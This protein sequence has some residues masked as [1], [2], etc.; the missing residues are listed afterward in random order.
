MEKVLEILKNK[1]FKLGVSAIS[2][3]YAIFCGYISWLVLAFYLKPTNNIS[4]FALYLFINFLFGAEMFYTRKSPVTRI[5][6]VI[7]PFEVFFM[8]I[9]G[10]GQWFVLIPP[11]VVCM[12]AFFASD[13][14]E[15]LKTVLGTI[16]L[17]LFVVGSLAYMTFLSFNISLNYVLTDEEMDMSLRQEDSYL[18]STDGTYRLVEYVEKTQ[19]RTT[20]KYYVELA[21]EDVHLPFIDC[22]RVL[23]CKKVL[24]S[25]YK[26]SAN[27]RWIS[28]TELYI[29][30]KKRDMEE[31]FADTESEDIVLTSA[32]LSE[33]PD[34]LTTPSD[35]TTAAE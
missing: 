34:A 21:S 35:E 12:F 32:V 26:E 18:V 7:V 31:L 28:D 33:A 23:G 13:N 22:Y 14:G 11:L 30:G 9:A 19:D 25:V 27:P 2:I 16:F 5:V 15:T 17:L 6:S 10:F 4:V 29:D 24:V 3:G 8:W 1:W 20:R